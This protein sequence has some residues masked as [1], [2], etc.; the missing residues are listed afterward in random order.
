MVTG[1]IVSVLGG[2]QSHPKLHVDSTR[3]TTAPPSP[4]NQATPLATP[5]LNLSFTVV[6]TLVTQGHL[7]P[8]TSGLLPMPPTAKIQQT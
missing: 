5:H 7:R 4:T 1:S 6:T 3:V 8:R 2:K